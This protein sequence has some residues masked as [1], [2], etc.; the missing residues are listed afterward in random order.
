MSYEGPTQ[1]YRRLAENPNLITYWSDEKL[2]KHFLDTRLLI[3]TDSGMPTNQLRMGFVFRVSGYERAEI[4][5]RMSV[6]PLR[7]DTGF[8]TE[9]NEELNAEEE[10]T[11][12]DKQMAEDYVKLWRDNC[13]QFER[14]EG[15]DETESG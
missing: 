4:L 3:E 5:R 14:G 8:D 7:E 6:S 2:L 12:E 10:I 11:P 15:K 1:E 13:A 9:G